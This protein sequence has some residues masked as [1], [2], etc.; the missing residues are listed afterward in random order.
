LFS[1][2]PMKPAVTYLTMFQV[3]GSPAIVLIT[4]RLVK[5]K[6]CDKCTKND[7]NRLVTRNTQKLS[8]STNISQILNI[9]ANI[10]SLW[11]GICSS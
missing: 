7:G 6:F 10:A 11:Q 1:T 9:C 3:Q 5:N 2:V 4:Q 8:F